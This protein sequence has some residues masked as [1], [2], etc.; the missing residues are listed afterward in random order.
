M[1]ARGE[2]MGIIPWLFLFFFIG[3][4]MAYGIYFI[5]ALAMEKRAKAEADHSVQKNKKII[6]VSTLL[7]N[8]VLIPLFNR[9]MGRLWE[10]EWATSENLF[11][12]IPG[13]LGLWF[14]FG[15]I[16][17]SVSFLFALA[18][19]FFLHRKDTRLFS[20]GYHPPYSGE[21]STGCIFAMGVTYTGLLV[22]IVVNLV[23]H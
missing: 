9:A 6:M 13:I 17:A 5:I 16:P 8:L 20:R 22:L 1:I 2:S 19:Y 14:V 10:V 11:R 7:F 3:I 4:P 12:S 15:M 18:V 21:V 23:A